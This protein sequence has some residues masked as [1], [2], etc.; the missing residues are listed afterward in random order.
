[1]KTKVYYITEVPHNW[2]EF[3]DDSLELAEYTYWLKRWEWKYRR[4][5][6]GII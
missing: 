5:I 1:M 2:R 6:L 4:R 3:S